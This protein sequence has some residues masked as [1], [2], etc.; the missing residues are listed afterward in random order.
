MKYVS[1]GSKTTAYNA[2]K[3]MVRIDFIFDTHPVEYIWQ[4]FCMNSTFR[5]VCLIMLVRWINLPTNKYHHRTAMQPVICMH[6]LVALKTLSRDIYQA[7]DWIWQ[8]THKRQTI[9]DKYDNNAKSGYL[10]VCRWQCSTTTSINLLGKS[11]SDIF[12]R[13]LMSQCTRYISTARTEFPILY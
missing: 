11:I 12:K 2:F 1:T 10:P 8:C 9:A 13:A 7:T 5:H 6:C 4:A 3:I